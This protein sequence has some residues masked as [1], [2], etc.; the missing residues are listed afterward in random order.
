LAAIDSALVGRSVNVVQNA[1][2][3][4]GEARHAG[5]GILGNRSQTTVAIDGGAA[6]DER[7][8]TEQ[9]GMAAA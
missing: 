2:V 5:C 7:A 8:A 6:G 9:R 4:D 1:G 3:V